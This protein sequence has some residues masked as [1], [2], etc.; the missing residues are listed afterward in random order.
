MVTRNLKAPALVL[1]ARPVG[2]NHRGLSMLVSGEGLI[3]PLAFG[4]QGKKSPLRGTAVPYNQG[5]ADL[6]YDGSR[7]RW[8]LTA[9]DPL[10]THD[11]LRENLDRF[12]AA[13]TW[14][15]IL[16]KTHGSGDDSALIFNLAARALSLLSAGE[17]R[18]IGRLNAGF[19]WHFLDIEGVRPD[20]GSCER[21]G[22]VLTAGNPAGPAR[23]L[24]NG[25]LAGPECSDRRFPELP[26]RARFWLSALSKGNLEDSLAADLPSR[27]VKAA[28]SWLLTIIQTLLE[29]PLR[30]IG[31]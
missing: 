18:D 4:A 20:P 29:R 9:F 19:L 31:H 17:S 1:N 3:T 24:P 10:N 26:D 2:E 22:R 13:S 28:E 14:A 7:D 5:I 25:L 15:E 11:G 6:H 16:L 27:D 23:F 21:C 12:Y 30:S 8:R